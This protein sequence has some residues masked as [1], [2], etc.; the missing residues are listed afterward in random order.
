MCLI[1]EGIELIKNEQNP[2][3]VMELETGYV[4]W[5]DHQTFKG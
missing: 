2:Y 3:F 1:C 4:V 5:G